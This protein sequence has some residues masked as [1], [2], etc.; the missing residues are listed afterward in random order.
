MW[1]DNTHFLT[2]YRCPFCTFDCDGF[3]VQNLVKNRCFYFCKLVK[4]VNMSIL[5]RKHT[6]RHCH[7]CK[8]RWVEKGDSTPRRDSTPKALQ[9]IGA[10]L[11]LWPSNYSCSDIA[12]NAVK[13]INTS[14]CL[15]SVKT[16]K[17]SFCFTSACEIQQLGLPLPCAVL[18][19]Q[20]RPTADAQSKDRILHLDSLM[21]TGL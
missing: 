7:S 9:G 13:Q 4:G 15:Q 19:K 14:G 8:L 18:P 5:L 1:A 21:F 17:F 6:Q 11:P 16:M 12:P 10:W 3:S 20:R 2:W